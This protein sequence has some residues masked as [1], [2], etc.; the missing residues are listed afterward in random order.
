[1]FV[2][3]IGIIG[4]FILVI[5]SYY[6]I[7]QSGKNIYV[8]NLG[9]ANS[10]LDSGDSVEESSVISK[11]D[12]MLSSSDDESDELNYRILP[13]WVIYN[14]GD[15]RAEANIMHGP[16]PPLPNFTYKMKIFLSFL[17]VVTSVAKSIELQWPDTF[18]E[19]LEIFSFV[20]MNY[21]L[22]NLTSADCIESVNYYS[23]YLVYIG[24]PLGIFLAI[25]LL[26]LLPKYLECCCHKYSSAA[27]RTR[28]TMNFWKLFLY[29]LF[30]IYPGVS[31]TVLKHYVCKTIR[32]GP[33]PDSTTTFLRSNPEI[34]C[35][36]E[37]WTRYAY[38][39]IPLIALY[40]LGIPLFF[41]VLLKKHHATLLQIRSFRFLVC[42]GFYFSDLV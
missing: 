7:L 42:F 2:S 25:L 27:S 12:Q 32:Y 6:I 33:E 15:P 9:N 37:R 30:L 18:K 29:S 14:E 5:I 21:L 22:K 23:T 20:N 39:S 24:S 13:D 19:F 16:P 4:I 41:F 38:G 10:Y 34:E 31:S 40:P 17:Q 35:G 26:Y 1:V 11:P 8:G 3:I 36:T 28:S